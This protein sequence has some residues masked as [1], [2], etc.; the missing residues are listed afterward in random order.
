MSVR[1]TLLKCH[2]QKKRKEKHNTSESSSIVYNAI[3]VLS[4]LRNS[5]SGVSECSHNTHSHLLSNLPLNR[6]LNLKWRS[7]WGTR[8]KIKTSWLNRKKTCYNYHKRK[9]ATIIDKHLMSS[10][11]AICQRSDNRLW[12]WEVSCLFKVRGHVPPQIF[13][14]SG[15]WMQLPK[16]KIIAEQIFVIFDTIKLYHSWLERSVHPITSC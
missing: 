3:S 12:E 6:C 5:A 4:N 15:F 14:P 16:D 10:S 7:W 1:P 11:R 2:I 9:N 13:E 8:V